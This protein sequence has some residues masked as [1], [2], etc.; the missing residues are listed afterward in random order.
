MNNESNRDFRDEF[1]VS[2]QQ[3]LLSCLI[4]DGDAFALC[5]TI[6]KPE[7]FNDTLKKTATYINNYVDE[8]QSLPPV[9]LIIAKTGVDL[10]ETEMG[11]VPTDFLLGQV[12]QFCKFRAMEIAIVKS[13]ALLDKG[14][15][16]DCEQLIK[17]AMTVSLIS[18][19][20]LNYFDDPKS[21]LQ[22]MLDNSKVISTGYDSLDSMLFGGFDI[23]GLNIFAANSGGGKSVLLQNLAVNWALAGHDVIYISLELSEEMIALRLDAMFTGYSTSYVT[24]N[25]AD[26][27]LKL[28]MLGRNAGTLTIKRLPGGVNT[29]AMRAYLK[30]YQIKTGRKPF[31]VLVD[32]LDLMAPNSGKIDPGDLF[33]KDKYVSEELRNMMTDMALVGATAS[34]FNR[35]GVST[36]EFDHSHI[37][38]GIS[39]INTSDNTMAIFAPMSFKEKGIFEIQFLKTRTAASVGKKIRLAYCNESMRLADVKADITQPSS[40][41]SIKEAADKLV[42]KGREQP[43]NT[44]ALPARPNILAIMNKVKEIPTDI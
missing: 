8:T 29:N 15:H 40:R 10:R 6:L 16:Q 44:T 11:Y 25:I 4:K 3:Y 21:R 22:A 12:E 26:T 9:D 38:G 30:E 33:V 37:A 7:Y 20:G 27:S 28:Q 31:A 35:S 19:L 18:E 1:N 14:H 43:A 24:H 36:E 5:R 32:Y 34:Q 23:G 13:I 41:D 42:T 2:V 39:K 17:E